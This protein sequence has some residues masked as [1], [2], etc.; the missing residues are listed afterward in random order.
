MKL[1]FSPGACSLSPHIVLAESGLPFELERVDLGAK[2]TAS[3]ADYW[4]INPK[5]YVPAMALNDG[6]VLTEGPAIVQYIA[7]LVPERQLAPPA[8]TMACYRLQE[9]LNFIT[10]ELHKGFSPLFNR[11][12]TEEWKTVVKELLGRRIGVVAKQLEGKAYLMGDTFT[13]ADAYL[14]TILRWSKGAHIDLA[15]WPGLPDYMGRVAARPAVHECLE[16]E[17]LR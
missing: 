2:K 10:S 9:H 1:Y 16:A 3:G 7:D 13:V 5:G 8:G 15:Q 11:K 17:R 6:Q 4:Q 14:F 12:V